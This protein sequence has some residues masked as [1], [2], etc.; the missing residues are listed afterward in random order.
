MTMDKRTMNP[1]VPCKIAVKNCNSFNC[2]EYSIPFTITSLDV[3]I[4]CHTSYFWG[5]FLRETHQKTSK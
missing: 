2:S 3:R 4:Y 5:E 1:E